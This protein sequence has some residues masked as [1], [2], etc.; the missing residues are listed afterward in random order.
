MSIELG[1]A[2]FQANALAP[3]SEALRGAVALPRLERR[4]QIRLALINV[5]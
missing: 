3:N 4:R 1:E 2:L 5:D